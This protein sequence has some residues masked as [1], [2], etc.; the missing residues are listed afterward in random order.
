MLYRLDIST[1]YFYEPLLFQIFVPLKFVQTWA[2]PCLLALLQSTAAQITISI[3]FYLFV[4]NI[5]QYEI[6][7]FIKVLTKVFLFK[8]D[9]NVKHMKARVQIFC[10]KYFKKITKKNGKEEIKRNIIFNKLLN[11]K[12]PMDEIKEKM[13]KR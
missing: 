4:S 12:F 3:N 8:F 10:L 5:I 7:V 11:T 13:T 2:F 9:L 6:S 1:F